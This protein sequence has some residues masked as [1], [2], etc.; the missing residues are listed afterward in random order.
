M[1]TKVPKACAKPTVDGCMEPTRSRQMRCPYCGEVR[2]T[3]LKTIYRGHRAYRR[4]RCCFCNTQFSTQERQVRWTRVERKWPGPRPSRKDWR[5]QR[6]PALCSFCEVMSCGTDFKQ[7]DV[8]RHVDHIV[9]VR[10]LRRL[11]AVNPNRAR[12][13][14]AFVEPAMGTSCRPT[15]DSV[16]EIG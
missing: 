9:P 10:L 12:I 8:R 3:V 5:R 15:T 11:K 6:R 14:S 1:T 13:F 16:W 2:T 7:T 4:R